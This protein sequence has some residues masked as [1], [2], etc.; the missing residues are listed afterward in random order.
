VVDVGF[1]EI[2][3]P[4]PIRV[5]PQLPVYQFHTAPVPSVPLV[6]LRVDELPEQIDGGEAEAVGVVEAVFIVTANDDEAP[7]PQLLVPSTVTFP[8]EAEP[9]K[10]TVIELVFVPVAMVAPEGNVQVYPVAP[11]IAPTE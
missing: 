7:E 10:S 8:E 1:T 3:V 5:P 4:E 2:E 11:E 6:I 9:E